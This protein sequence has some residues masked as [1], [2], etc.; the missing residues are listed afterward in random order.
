VNVGLADAV[1]SRWIIAQRRLELRPAS[2]G[3]TIRHPSAPA[4]GLPHITGGTAL[5]DDGASAS[6]RASEAANGMRYIMLGTREP[7]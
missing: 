3:V 7:Q 5:S 2:S 4:T 6:T 1:Q